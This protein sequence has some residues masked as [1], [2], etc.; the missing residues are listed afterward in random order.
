M[1][2]ITTMPEI[3]AGIGGRDLGKRIRDGIEQRFLRSRGRSAEQRFEFREG[4][5]D[6]RQIRGVRWEIP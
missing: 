1:E 5:F 3:A 4:L 6:G 2:T